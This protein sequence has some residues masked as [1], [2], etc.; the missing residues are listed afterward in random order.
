MQL[1]NALTYWSTKSSQTVLPCTA[2]E[3]VAPGSLSQTKLK[4]SPKICNVTQMLTLQQSHQV[5]N[6][7]EMSIFSGHILLSTTTDNNYNSKYIHCR[8]IPDHSG[9]FLPVINIVST[10]NTFSMIKNFSKNKVILIIFSFIS[11]SI[12]LVK[13]RYL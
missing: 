9:N 1:S 13:S 7:R 4:T 2:T 12:V 11:S 3:C 5:T 10:V 8:P 6:V